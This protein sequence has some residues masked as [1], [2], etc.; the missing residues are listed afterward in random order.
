MPLRFYNTLTRREEEFV[1]LVPGQVG[2]YVIL[3]LVGAL[4]VLGAVIGYR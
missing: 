3:F 4:W 2:M 1:P